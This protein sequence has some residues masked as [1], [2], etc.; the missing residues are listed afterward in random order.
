[1][2]GQL[3]HLLR[4]LCISIVTLSS[5]GYGSSASTVSESYRE[6]LRKLEC[7]GS[8]K[9][10]EDLALDLQVL[11]I[12]SSVSLEQLTKRAVGGKAFEDI[13]T[14]YEIGLEPRASAVAKVARD[15]TQLIL[16]ENPSSLEELIDVN[17]GLVS[18]PCWAWQATLKPSLTQ[19]A[20][21]QEGERDIRCYPTRPAAPPKLKLSPPPS[22]V[23]LPPSVAEKLKERRDLVN[24]AP[25]GQLV[26]Q[27]WAQA[28][29]FV[30][31][32][33]PNDMSFR[34]T[35]PNSY[36]LGDAYAWSRLTTELGRSSPTSPPPFR[37]VVEV[38]QA[39]VASGACDA[40]TSHNRGQYLSPLELIVSIERPPD[41]VDA[42]RKLARSKNGSELAG[43]L[44]FMH[45]GGEYLPEKVLNNEIFGIIAS[46]NKT[47]ARSALFRKN[48]RDWIYNSCCV[49][50]G[51]DFAETIDILKAIVRSEI[52]GDFT[53]YVS[54]AL[55]EIYA[56]GLGT[57]PSEREAAKWRRL[58]GLAGVGRYQ[59]Y[60]DG[61][62]SVSSAVE[63]VRLFMADW[64]EKVGPSEGNIEVTRVG[65]FLVERD[66]L[67]PTHM[68]AELTRI[69]QLVSLHKE[70][71]DV[72]LL[73]AEPLLINAIAERLLEGAGH[74][75]KNAELAVILLEKAAQ[76]GNNFASTRLSLLYFY[77]LGTP[78]DIDRALDSATKAARNGDPFAA[79]LAADFSQMDAAT[80]VDALK[81]YSSAIN[82]AS[83][84]NASYMGEYSPETTQLVNRFIAGNDLLHGPDGISMLR[85]LADAHPQVG[86]A[87]GDAYVCTSCESIVDP[88]EASSWYRLAARKGDRQGR[89]SLARLLIAFPDLQISPFEHLDLLKANLGDKFDVDMLINNEHDIMESFLLFKYWSERYGS[90]P[91]ELLFSMRA[92][93]LEVC[94]ESSG[95]CDEV[96]YHFA[97]GVIDPSLIPIGLRTLQRPIPAPQSLQDSIFY[98]QNAGYVVDILTSIGAFEN[99][100]TE[101]TRRENNLL[102]GAQLSFEFGRAG[103][104]RDILRRTVSLHLDNG[105]E[106]PKSLLDLVQF[107]A[108]RGDETS[109][110]LKSMIDGDV[111]M[112]DS[113]PDRLDLG[114]LQKSFQT[115]LSRGAIS[116]GLALAARELSEAL[117]LEGDFPNSLLQ[118][119]TALSVELQ[120]D[121]VS[122]GT[123]GNF[124]ASLTRACH[125]SKSSE[126]VRRLGYSDAAIALAKEAV[127]TLQAQRSK[128][129]E[130]PEQL[131]ACFDDAISEPYRKLAS[132]L[133]EK[134][135]LAEGEYVR[136]LI[137]GGE[138]DR[139]MNHDPAY[140]GRSFDQV[141]TAIQER[142]VR[143]AI[144]NLRP[145]VTLLWARASAL[146]AKESGDKLS[147]Q[148]RDELF[149]IE[150]E[151][152]IAQANY[153]QSLEEAKAAVASLNRGIKGIFLAEATQIQNSLAA[154]KDRIVVL[155]YLVLPDRMH[156][157]VTTKDG[158]TSH[159][160]KKW[161]G[162]DFTEA[163]LNREIRE[164]ID[165]LRNK[166]ESPLVRA[167]RMYRLL[168]GPIER[169]IN[170]ARPEL[171][172]ISLDRRLNYIP[173]AAL[174][175]ETEYLAQ[176][177]ALASLSDAGFELGDPKLSNLP[178]AA[179]GTTHRVADFEALPGVKVELAGLVGDETRSGLFPGTVK[180]DKAFNRNAF[181]AALLFGRDNHNS[182]AIVHLSS[183]FEAARTKMD[184]F[185]LLGNGD[186]LYVDEIVT[187][188]LRFSF[189]HVDL[190]TL[191]A[192]STG[193]AHETDD[194]SELGS[195]ATA[196][197]K[198]GAR[199]VLAS[200]W[201]ISDKTTPLIL[202]R[203]Y[204]IS[205]RGPLTRASALAKAQSEFIEGR[206]DST[207][208][209]DRTSI[210]VE[211]AQQLGVPL[212]GSKP[213][214]NFSH[215]YYWAPFVLMGNWQ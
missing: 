7:I 168:L 143:E 51:Q 147:S 35:L 36:R 196:V 46:S 115:Q 22:S 183:H 64:K 203:F 14:Q 101:G 96:A 136:H 6:L 149:Q 13:L 154:S 205:E 23:R 141:P 179:L 110:A 121:T 56:H 175:T 85:S 109:L 87:I 184:S 15:A 165:V 169:D 153:D 78:V 125:L 138:V 178:M 145:P 33:Y 58:A 91:K 57:A 82:I 202:Q 59:L 207:I 211:S 194:G 53:K 160:W 186:K 156:V 50:E 182:K 66:Q 166:A 198:A 129:R 2:I 210:V 42:L 105:T 173:F 60:I 10:R 49:E 209:S 88:A 70:A 76:S 117:A 65:P 38:G 133:I 146:V 126:V 1:M 159:T 81:W 31:G 119:M 201:K 40:A 27:Y 128:I 142:D 24:C 124:S 39:R 213:L 112:A 48:M 114:K 25:T 158:W 55:A 19:M 16:E 11:S 47:V 30:H 9:V 164:F 3:S 29:A 167:K 131:R 20:Y 139:Y 214:G 171:L 200:L 72:V 77:G 75:G 104:R 67:I 79:V 69:S 37:E 103:N 111:V 84:S 113:T 208:P 177:Y 162:E 92:L 98:E 74:D 99:A 150:N 134:E 176:K 192:C 34:D 73:E 144:A 195:L 8:V 63:A 28:I 152:K 54:G 83:K 161:G 135:R 68:A 120:L 157:L 148:E 127:N 5:S 71:R 21:E 197:T 90:N 189:K 108:S 132:M 18:V 170:T 62:E 43:R 94:D 185:L 107:L 4:I 32:C 17:G 89:L 116:K 163:L 212:T 86:R 188:H 102:K 45:L 174:H 130:L 80:K 180:L 206:F 97:S 191:S 190:L 106:I 44:F 12:W 123:V 41:D 52:S 118:E 26:A 181:T 137:K 199:S 204:E 187:Q 140:A 151:L 193:F 172:L 215:P 155:R 122:E 93:L 61:L 95:A 100:I